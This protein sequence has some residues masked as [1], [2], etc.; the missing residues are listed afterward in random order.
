[1][2]LAWEAFPLGCVFGLLSLNNS[3]PRFFIEKYLGARELGIFAALYAP[4]AG[5]RFIISALGNTA[6]RRLAKYFTLR[7]RKAFVSLLVKLAGIGA[8]IG[9]AGI[10]IAALAGREILD[11]LYRPEYGEYAG[12]FF[13]LMVA[14]GVYFLAVFMGYGM[15]AAKQFW[16]QIPLLASTGI[17]S[18]LACYYLVP[19]YGI[20]G[21]AISEVIT[22]AALF[23]SYLTIILYIIKYRLKIRPD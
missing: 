18:T 20:S 17:V 11:L 16:A 3:I 23:T 21:A 2:K 14:T 9:G 7:D 19:N 5:G 6:S 4:A 10:G 22:Q 15:T 12:T 13:W 1:M 8:L